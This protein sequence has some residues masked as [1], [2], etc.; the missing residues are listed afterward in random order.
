MSENK[1]RTIKLLC[2]SLPTTVQLVVA[3][4][5]QKL[6]LGFIAGTFGVDP[7]TVMLNGHFIGRGTDLIASSVTWKSLLSFFSAKGL[8]TGKND[9]TP[10]VVDGK[11]CRVGAKR[12]GHHPQDDAVNTVSKKMRTRSNPVSKFRGICSKRKQLLEDLNSLKKLK[13]NETSPDIQARSNDLCNDISNPKPK[14]R[15][16][17]SSGRMKRMREDEAVEVAPYKRLDEALYM[18]RI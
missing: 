17:Y 3:D 7:S 10:I 9:D 15:C 13:I 4:E 6:D 11:L 16:S 2:P 5:E 1:G 18:L 14:F 8:P 12:R